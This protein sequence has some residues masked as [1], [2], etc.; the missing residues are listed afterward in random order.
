MIGIFAVVE[1]VFLL[2]QI[3][4]SGVCR[5]IGYRVHDSFTFG[6][7]RNSLDKPSRY[8]DLLV[9]VARR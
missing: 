5:H 9:G 1:S 4:I 3:M 2:R 7:K 8:V 6:V